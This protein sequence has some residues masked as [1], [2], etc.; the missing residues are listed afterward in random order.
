MKESITYKL[1]LN[2]IAPIS[3]K[4]ANIWHSKDFSIKKST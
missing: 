1:F 3:S 4:R 2:T